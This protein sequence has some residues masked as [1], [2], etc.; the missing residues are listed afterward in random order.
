MTQA[1]ARVLAADMGRMAHDPLRWVLYAYKWN[2]PDGPLTGMSGPQ[3][4]QREHLDYVGR[5]LREEPYSP[6]RVAVSSGHG[7]GKSAIVDFDG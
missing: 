2:E 7:I 1:E 5:R 3:Q 4:W 6:I